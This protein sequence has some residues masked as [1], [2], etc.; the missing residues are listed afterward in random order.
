MGDLDVKQILKDFMKRYFNKCLENLQILN[1]KKENVE[2]IN[3]IL[4]KIYNE[5]SLQHELGIFLRNE[6]KSDERKYNKNNNYNYHILFEYNVKKMLE[7]NHNKSEIDIVI[8]ATDKENIEIKEKYAIELK[9]PKNGAYPQE[10][11][12]FEED[13]EFMQEVKDSKKA[14][15]NGAYCL[16]VVD[17]KLYYTQTGL[18]PQKKVKTNLKL[19]QEFRTEKEEEKN[20]KKSK[21]KNKKVCVHKKNYKI[22]WNKLYKNN[23]DDEKS[24]KEINTI[25]NNI[26]ELENIIK[27]LKNLRYYIVEI[28]NCDDS[29]KDLP[30]N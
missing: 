28:D 21:F 16:T 17:D 11:K 9:Y 30:K 14:K 4:N 19:Y 7:N 24:N 27:K 29:S 10:L 5:I 15:F 20:K 18:E 3:K 6:L 13:I 8:V 1:A 23:K 22:E 2:E 12:M 25:Y 26:E